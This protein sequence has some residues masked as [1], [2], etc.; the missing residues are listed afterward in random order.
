MRL[1]QTHVAG[2]EDCQQTLIRYA[3]PGNPGVSEVGGEV[4]INVKDVFAARTPE[5]ISAHVRTIEAET[6]SRS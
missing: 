6:G 4:I 1:I 2:C 3:V 5:Q